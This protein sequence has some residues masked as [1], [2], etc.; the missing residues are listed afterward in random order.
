M[1]RTR[2]PKNGPGDGEMIRTTGPNGILSKEYRR[3]VFGTLLGALTDHVHESLQLRTPNGPGRPSKYHED[4]CQ[5]VPLM[6]SLGKSKYVVARDLGVD[7]D[8]LGNWGNEHPEFFGA[9]KIGEDWSRAWW[10][11]EGRMALRLGQFEKFSTG[12]W[13]I[14]MIN[15]FGWKSANSQIKEEKSGIVEQIHTQ[16]KVIEINLGGLTDETLNK[17]MVLLSQAKTPEGKLI[18]AEP[19][20]DTVH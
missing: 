6:M 19:V 9:L 2:P 8:T 1:T 16:K 7:V 18:A 17:F 15:K 13:L 11:E 10:E 20:R 3:A 14:N 5:I 4:L 12:P